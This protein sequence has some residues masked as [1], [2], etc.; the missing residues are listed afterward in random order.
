MIGY[1]IATG[2]IASSSG[3]TCPGPPYL[4]W[5][6]E[7][8]PGILYDLDAG[9]AALLRLIGITKEEGQKL[10]DK[11]RLYLAPYRI[12]Y[13]PGRL[14]TIDKGFGLGHKWVNF[15]DASQYRRSMFTDQEDTIAM[16]LSAEI[17]ED[18]AGMVAESF[19]SLGLP[20]GRL[21]SPI[22]AFSVAHLEKLSLPKVG[23]IPAAVVSLAQ[24]CIKG[25]WFEA[26]H[27]GY[28][29][30]AWDYDLNGAYASELAHLLD[31]RRG[32]WVQ[33]LEEPEG[34]VYGFAQGELKTWAELHPFVT[35]GR[36]GN[37][38]TP[39][40]RWETVLTKKELDFLK[41]FELGSFTVKDAWWWIPRGYPSRPLAGLVAW[42]WGKRITAPPLTREIIKRILAGLWGKSLE[43]R[44]G[45]YGQ[46]YNP[47]WGAIVECN[48]RVKVASTCLVG[49]VEPLHIALDGIVVDGELNLPYLTPE[50]NTL[51]AWRLSHTGQCIIGS[52]GVVGME[53][54]DNEEEFS[55]TF[56]WLM[57]QISQDPDAVS[58]SMTTWSPVTLG[59]ALN[60]N[61]WEQLGEVRLLTRAVKIGGDFKRVWKRQPTTGRELIGQSPYSSMPW[62]VNIVTRGGD[63]PECPKEIDMTEGESYE[64]TG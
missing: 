38:F 9:A 61:E 57:E 59:Q 53:G 46:Y 50:S 60:W 15:C 37:L 51:G 27:Q 33:S 23:D 20:A 32:E 62:L 7:R 64:A 45:E 39:V 16:H 30:E 4:D 21:T 25:S 19:E 40:G 31:L 58:Y 63:K 11:G 5:L 52:S 56:D 17:A 6:V 29:R 26:Y 54:K 35:K 47:V 28:F 36:G 14:L 44:R 2:G 22:A 8:E 55:I 48:T 3:E 24:Q 43:V 13:F 12:T 1:H 34:A 18:I 10:W 42:L 49:G 41:E